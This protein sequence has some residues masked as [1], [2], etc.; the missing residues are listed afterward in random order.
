M[1]IIAVWWSFTM[2]WSCPSFM[3]LA[4]YNR[5]FQPDF[6]LK[7]YAWGMNNLWIVHPYKCLSSFKHHYFLP[8]QNAIP[9]SCPNFLCIYF[10]PTI[11]TGNKKNVRHWYVYVGTNLICTLWKICF[12]FVWLK[13][14]IVDWLFSVKV[15]LH[16]LLYNYYNYCVPWCCLYHFIFSMLPMV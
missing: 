10:L 11:S 7:T 5:P 16:Y 3:V 6:Q 13:M 14:S 4:F 9:Q 2:F 12:P 15:S 1:N 8:R